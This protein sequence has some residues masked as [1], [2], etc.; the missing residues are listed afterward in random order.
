MV[1]Y[2]SPFQVLTAII[3]RFDRQLLG[4][5]LSFA[6]CSMHILFDSN[7]FHKFWMSCACRNQLS[8]DSR[9]QRKSRPPGTFC[10]DRPDTSTYMGPI[11]SPE[12][13]DMFMRFQ[14]KA[15]ISYPV[16][17]PG[18]HKV[19]L[20]RPHTSAKIIKWGNHPFQKQSGVMLCNVGE[21][22]GR[23]A[24]EAGRPAYLRLPGPRQKYPRK[25]PREPTSRR[26][27]EPSTESRWPDGTPLGRPA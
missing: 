25:P 9:N 19:Q 10:A 21:A 2:F 22:E 3:S 16:G 1:Q 6:P 24:P 11:I 26:D 27:Q 8:K 17:G 13:C 15:N 5:K 7:K 18:R 14:N 4:N 12:K 23:G 20:K